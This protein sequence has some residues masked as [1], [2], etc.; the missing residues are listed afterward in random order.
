MA[1]IEFNAC[2]SFTLSKVAQNEQLNEDIEAKYLAVSRQT[3]KFC[4]IHA[5]I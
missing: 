4:H 2:S 3:V 5:Q 1:G